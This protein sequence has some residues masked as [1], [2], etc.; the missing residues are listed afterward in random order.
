MRR[1][2]STSSGAPPH[3]RRQPDLTHTPLAPPQ[4]AGG[5]PDSTRSRAPHPTEELGGHIVV[6]PGSAQSFENTPEARAV[7]V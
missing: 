6:G 7:S 5:L 3:A 1:L 2:E 4:P